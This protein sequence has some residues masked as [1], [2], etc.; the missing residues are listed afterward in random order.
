M[1]VALECVVLSVCVE[2][3]HRAVRCSHASVAPF[4]LRFPNVGE[5]DA[6]T[7]AREVVPVPWVLVDT[8]LRLLH[9]PDSVPQY[10]TVI[11]YLTSVEAHGT[12]YDVCIPVL[13]PV[14]SAVAD[15][16]AS[17]MAVGKFTFAFLFHGSLHLGFISF[18]GFSPFESF[19]KLTHRRQVLI[20]LRSF[21]G[22]LIQIAEVWF[23]YC[24]LD[25]AQYSG[26]R[27]SIVLDGAEVCIT[28]V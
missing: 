15:E 12:R 16:L 17:L 5:G 28:R 7:V 19:F 25:V 18:F 23:G 13:V 14:F 4:R 26:T 8:E 1:Q 21:V 20:N 10:L 9:D 2:A 22:W 24:A 6:T 3:R 27:S 11:R